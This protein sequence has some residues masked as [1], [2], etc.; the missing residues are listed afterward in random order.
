MFPRLKTSLHCC[1]R[2]AVLRWATVGLCVASLV[3][4]MALYLANQTIP[5]TLL[6]L[7][8]VATLGAVVQLGLSARSI[9]LRP[10]ELA[11]RMLKVQEDERQHLSRELHDDIGQLLTA[12]KLQL[13]WLQRRMPEDLQGHCEALRSTLDDTLGNVRDVSALLNPRQLASL[14][15]EAS[16]RAHLVRTLASS[17]VHWSLACNQRLGGIDEAV[18]MAVFRITQEAVTNMLRHAQAHN[19]VIRLQRT[20][21]GL[22]LSIHDDGRGFAPA[23]HPAEAGQRGLAGMQERVIALQ[24][25]LD[26]TS[27]PGRGTQ[28]EAMFPWS[29][30]TQQRARSITNHDL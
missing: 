16:L 2:A 22:A 19:L 30:R 3:A 28:I 25:S 29:P 7:Q 14:G 27:Q 8:L 11:E 12:A 26:I 20:P 4:N 5:A 23:R 9:H 6:V 21:E 1:S 17:G 10:A 18:A 24:G 15:L 13:Q